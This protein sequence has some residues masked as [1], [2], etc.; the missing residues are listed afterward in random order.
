MKYL[1]GTEQG[2]IVSVNLRNRKTNN[3]VSLFDDGPGKHHGPVYSIQRNPI[4][5]KFF[6]SVGDWTAK[7]WSE[8]LKTPIITTKYHENYLT[9]GCWSP[10]RVGVF[11]TITMDGTL[12]AWD[13]FFRQ[14]EVA[15][16]HKVGH[17]SLSSIGVQGRGKLLAVGDVNGAVSLLEVGDSLASPQ[18]GEKA[19]LSNTFEREARREKNLEMREKEMKRALLSQDETEKENSSGDAAL[20]KIDE[21]FKSL[22]EG[23]RE[24]EGESK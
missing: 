18:Q 9:G 10:T 16:T 6:L 13:L 14:N 3:G 19:S 12:N 5:N 15:Y 2:S 23:L 20:T 1:V 17:A 24:D 21:K 22:M 11:Y 7:I 8:D 4:H